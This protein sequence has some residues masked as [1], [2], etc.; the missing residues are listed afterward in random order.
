MANESNRSQSPY[1]L[2]EDVGSFPVGRR[3]TLSNGGSAGVSVISIDSQVQA[4][5]SFC[6]EQLLQLRINSVI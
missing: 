2:L 6:S 5:P 4:R 3:D 1:I